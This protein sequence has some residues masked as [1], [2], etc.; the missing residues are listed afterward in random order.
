VNSKLFEGERVRLK[1]MDPNQAEWYARCFHDSEFARLLGTRP[2]MPLSL[3]HA[4][5][6]LAEEPK[7]HW[8]PFFFHARADDRLLGMVD[9]DVTWTH[10]NAWVGI[11]VGQRDDWGQGYGTE[12][13]RLI[14]R[15]S[16][17]ELNLR[18]V[19]LSVFGYN[20]RALRAYENVGFVLEGRQRQRIARDGQWHD[21]LFMGILK[22]EWEKERFKIQDSS[23]KLE[24]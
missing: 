23:S 17:M 9:L 24:S 16:F 4:K 11:G 1:A 19:T 18:R 15:Y 10:R 13:M 7:P 3:Q 22:E 14:L 20:S 2:A 21:I 5:D 8:F 6:E 12:A